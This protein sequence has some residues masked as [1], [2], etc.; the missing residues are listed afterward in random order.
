MA[1]PPL[2]TVTDDAAKAGE[3]TTA[4]PFTVNWHPADQRQYRRSD[5]RSRRSTPQA[6]SI[7]PRRLR[8]LTDPTPPCALTGPSPSTN[9]R[10]K[11]VWWSFTSATTQSI[12]VSTI[13]SVYDTTLSVWTGTPGNLT[14]V[15]CNDDVS[16][17]QY[18]QSMLS[19]SATA[20]TNYYI[21]VAPFGP[22]DTG[23][24]SARRAR[25]F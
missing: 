8:S 24:G 14:N 3:S 1:R 15:A 2:V 13:G 19:F 22:P 17:G 11:T 10:T 9:P 21:M 5:R 16:S 7:I 20:G 23:P 6:P 12:I 18:T 25:Q 4:Q